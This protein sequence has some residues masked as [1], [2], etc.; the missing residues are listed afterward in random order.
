MRT[1]RHS[2]ERSLDLPLTEDDPII[3]KVHTV[4]RKPQV[5]GGPAA[6]AVARLED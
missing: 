3:P 5:M 2:I 6:S 4:V 1:I